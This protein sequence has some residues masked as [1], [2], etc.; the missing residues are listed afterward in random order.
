MLAA[1]A[2]CLPHCERTDP[3]AVRLLQLETEG[4]AS[5]VL[6]PAGLDAG[7]EAA[8]AAEEALVA[9]YGRVSETL[10]QRLA[11]ATMRIADDYLV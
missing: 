8:E 3:Q 5:A 11:R 9:R 4:G 6:G 1:S 7:V 10:M 2:T